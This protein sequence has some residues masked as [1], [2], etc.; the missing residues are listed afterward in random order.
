[1][2]GLSSRAWPVVDYR[3]AM[4]EELRLFDRDEL[5]RR[6]VEPV[7]RSLVLPDE[8][9]EISVTIEEPSS[10]SRYFRVA[11]KARGEWISSTQSWW[12]YEQSDLE[13]F[14]VDLYDSLR[15]ELVESRL[16]WGERRDGQYQVLGPRQT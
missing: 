13:A 1:V 6:V 11:L 4:P 10:S 15:D 2:H 8:L 5:R 12:V 9:E 7:V 16:S 14:A 3:R